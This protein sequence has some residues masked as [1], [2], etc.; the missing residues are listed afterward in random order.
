MTDDELKAIW[1]ASNERM[2][3][4]NL[5]TMK[6]NNMNEQIKKF[7]KTIRRRNNIEI[8]VHILTY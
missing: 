8:I 5:H 1:Q 3:V 4:I 6:L 2:H 7:G